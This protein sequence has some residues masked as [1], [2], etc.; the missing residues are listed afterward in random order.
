MKREP[1]IVRC[2]YSTDKGAYSDV[3]E[4]PWSDVEEIAPGIYLV[5]ID[6]TFRLFDQDGTPCTGLAKEDE[7]TYDFAPPGPIQN[8]DAVEVINPHSLLYGFAGKAI[9]RADDTWYV[10][11][12][13]GRLHGPVLSDQLKII[14]RQAPKSDPVPTDDEIMYGD[15]SEP[16]KLGI[17]SSEK[18]EPRNCTTCRFA[19]HDPEV[20]YDG[21]IRCT[22]PCFEGWVKEPNKPCGLWQTELDKTWV[23]C[24]LDLKDDT[25]R[26]LVVGRAARALTNNEVSDKALQ[27]MLSKAWAIKPSSQFTGHEYSLCLQGA[28]EAL[29]DGHDNWIPYFVE[30]M[31]GFIDWGPPCESLHPNCRCVTIPV[32]EEP[33]VSESNTYSYEVV[34][35]KKTHL[36][37]N[38][39]GKDVEVVDREKILVGYGIGVQNA[40]PQEA[41][42]GISAGAP[43]IG[44]KCPATCEALINAYW[45]KLQEAGVT[46]GTVGEVV[47][48][49]SS[50]CPDL[51]I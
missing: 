39:E 21:H 3:Q 23:P 40:E 48:R 49:I 14:S 45:G 19:R 13:D 15:G 10:Q 44:G 7:P 5:S 9:A 20:P 46:P 4:V 2:D 6:S 31:G 34:L 33:K 32:G 47:V 25:A 50:F 35:P 16:P 51:T 41:D 26:V 29:L 37:K 11:T 8:G 18:C 24:F 42:D 22:L 27:C 43:Q 30:S 38:A 1:I 12:R 36:E 28:I 17:L